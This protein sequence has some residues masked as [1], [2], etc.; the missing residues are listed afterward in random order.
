M[1]ISV[2]PKNRGQGSIVRLR[3]LTSDGVC[4]GHVELPFWLI[5]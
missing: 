2:T 4:Q 3:E 5:L 1:H